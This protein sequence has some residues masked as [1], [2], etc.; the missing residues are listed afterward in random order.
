MTILAFV[1][2]LTWYIERIVENWLLTSSYGLVRRLPK[3]MKRAHKGADNEKAPSAAWLRRAGRSKRMQGGF[4]LI[5]MGKRLCSGDAVVGLSLAIPWR[6]CVVPNLDHLV[7][8]SV[9]C[10]NVVIVKE[11]FRKVGES[12]E[13]FH[14]ERAC[15]LRANEGTL[16]TAET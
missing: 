13:V 6:A 14:R 8:G 7:S 16:A 4:S 10:L 12:F 11:I 15:P 1:S 9:H 5:P 3:D 2:P